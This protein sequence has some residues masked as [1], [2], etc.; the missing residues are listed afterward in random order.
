MG[1]GMEGAEKQHQQ[2]IKEAQDYLK[3][4]IDAKKSGDD[5]GYKTNYLQYLAAKLKAETDKAASKDAVVANKNDTPTQLYLAAQRI[6]QNDPEVVDARKALE[7]ARKTGEPADVTA[8]TNR[9]Q[10]VIQQ[11]QAAH[12][13]GVGLKPQD[14]AT[15]AKQPGNTQE[16]PINGKQAGLTADNITK[17]LQSGQWFTNPSDGKL[18]Q[19]KGP[20]EKKDDTSKSSTPSKTTKPEPANPENRSEVSNGSTKPKTDDDD[21]D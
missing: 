13:A 14:A 10:Q 12:L 18:L 9:L 1:S 3:L 19:Y 5:Q 11:K 16:N 2:Q 8:A 20:P 17:K 15:I 21:E 4:A 7:S 6:V